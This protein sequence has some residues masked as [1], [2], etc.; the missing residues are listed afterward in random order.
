MINTSRRYSPCTVDY[1]ELAPGEQFRFVQEAASASLGFFGLGGGTTM[2]EGAVVGRT[3]TGEGQ[4]CP[5]GLDFG[6]SND[7]V[8]HA[9]ML[10]EAGPSGAKWICISNNGSGE[11]EIQHLPVDG[12]ATIPAG[13]GFVVATG[14]VDFETKTATQFKYAAPRAADFTVTGTADLLLVR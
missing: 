13:W 10:L 1:V 3:F 14:S 9:E 7:K 11:R 8:G 6:W 12:S 5:N 2:L 4:W